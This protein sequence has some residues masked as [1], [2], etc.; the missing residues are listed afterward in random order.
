[1]R[2]DVSSEDG[3]MIAHEI[4][5]HI[6]EMDFNYLGIVE[7]ITISIGLADL[8]ANPADVNEFTHLAESALYLAKHNGRN[9]V[10]VYTGEIK[11][12]LNTYPE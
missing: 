2:M 4:C 12:K 9:R 10:E 8:S 3:F 11:D 1:M 5:H 6:G 7:P